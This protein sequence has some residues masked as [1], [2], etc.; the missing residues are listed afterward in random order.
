MSFNNDSIVFKDD[1]GY[2]CAVRKN[3]Y[4]YDQAHEIAWKTLVEKCT[5]GEHKTIKQ[6]HDYSHMYYGYGSSDGDVHNNWWLIDNSSK[7]AIPVYVFRGIANL[8]ED[9]E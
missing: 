5:Y 8:D 9:Y 2:L 7:N 4:N 6:C 3:M 1:K